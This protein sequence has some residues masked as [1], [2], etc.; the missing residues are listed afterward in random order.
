[1][2]SFN[3][4]LGAFGYPAQPTIGSNLQDQIAVLHWVQDNIEQFGGNPACV[5][6]FG[7]SAGGHAVRMLGC[8]AA[9]GLFQHAIL[10]SGG[11]ERFAFDRSPPNEKTFAASEALMAHVGGGEPE[12]LRRLPTEVVKEASHLFSGVIPKPRRV[13]TPANLAWMP[14]NSRSEM[15]AYDPEPTFGELG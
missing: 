10:Q 13:H 5:T 9:S 7:Q 1:M 15:T 2:T 3:Y 14:V 4:G 11:C 8:P 6:I 12:Q